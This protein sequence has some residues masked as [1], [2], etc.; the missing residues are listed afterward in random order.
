MVVVK[1]LLLFKHN[2]DAVKD[3]T[4]DLIKTA[5]PPRGCQKPLKQDELYEADLT[6]TFVCI[7]EPFSY[8]CAYQKKPDHSCSTFL[9]HIFT[10]LTH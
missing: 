6:H 4:E 10:K 9:P 2:V 7:I 1:Y 3:I 5:K 8:D